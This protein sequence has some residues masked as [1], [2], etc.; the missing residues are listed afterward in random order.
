[1]TSD[2]I[3]VIAPWFAAGERASRSFLRRVVI[4]LTEMGVEQFVD[5]AFGAPCEPDLDEIIRVRNPRARLVHSIDHPRLDRGQP[6]GVL[7]VGLLEHL[8][9][10]EIADLLRAVRRVSSPDSCLAIAHLTA[11]SAAF[12]WCWRTKGGP[13]GATARAWRQATINA[14]EIQRPRVGPLALRTGQQIRDLFL[15][16]ELL[17]PGLVP[18]DRWRAPG[19]RG[20]GPVPVLA[21][22]GR[23]LEVTASGAR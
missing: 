17:R 12:D 23:L 21:G 16:Y 14:V 20:P 3:S 11:D 9:D 10:E 8:T 13:A 15:E 5:V 22:V 2:P 1:M 18:A 4:H 19:T 6:V 7:M